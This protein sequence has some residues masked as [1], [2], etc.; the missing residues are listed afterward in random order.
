M[1]LEDVD[2]RASGE[3]SVALSRVRATRDGVTAEWNMC[4]VCRWRDG[5]VAEEWVFVE[6]Q[7]AYDEFWS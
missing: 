6:D 4:E 1:Q 5:Q 2:F 7:D 3:R